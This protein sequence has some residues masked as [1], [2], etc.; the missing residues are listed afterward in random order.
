MIFAPPV[1]GLIGLGV[2][3]SVTA[4]SQKVA[5]GVV[6]VVLLFAVLGSVVVDEDT[7]EVALMLVAVTLDARFT[8]TMMFEDAP[9]ARL[10]FVQ[11][12]LPVAPTAGVVQ[13]QPAGTEIEA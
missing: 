2:P 6:T 11:V 9:D 5:T 12:T 1:P 13:V 8:T 4:K 10:G 3:L 7:V